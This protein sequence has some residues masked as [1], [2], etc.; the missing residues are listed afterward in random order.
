MRA[1]GHRD[2]QHVRRRGH[3]GGAA[4]K[5]PDAIVVELIVMDGVS[6]KLMRMDERAAAGQ[7]AECAMDR[8]AEAL[9]HLRPRVAVEPAEPAE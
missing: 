3:R 2:V 8:M 9:R 4:V 6:G 7:D 1:C 5:A